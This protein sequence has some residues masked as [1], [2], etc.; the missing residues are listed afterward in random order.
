MKQRPSILLLAGLVGLAACG[1]KMETRKIAAA[2]PLT[3]R[4]AAAEGVEVTPAIVSTASF[5]A[6]EA[7]ELGPET[8]GVV[9]EVYV[10]VG[11]AVAA[12]QP[13]LRLESREAQWRLA[14]AQARVAEMEAVWRQAEARL[15]AD[16]RRNLNLSAEVLNAQ[17]A[18]DAAEEDARLA[19][20]E[21]ARANRLRT[22]KD[23]SQSSYDRAK[24]ALL[25]AEARRRGA[26]Q[27]LAAA[28]NVAQQSAQGIDIARAQ[29]ESARAQAAQAQKRASDTVLRAPFPGVVTA[30]TVSVGE[31]V[32]LQSKPLRVEKVDPLK[33]VFALP[34]ADA[35]RVQ[36]GL[37]VEAQVSALPGEVFRGKLRSPNGA[38][39]SA[40]RALTVEAEFANPSRRLKPGYFAEGKIL[41]GGAAA[42]LR[43]PAAA[44]D[45]DPRT[46]TYR[47]WSEVN[48]KAKLHLV[49][50]PRKAGLV[51]ELL[52]A[53]AAGLTAGARVI[54][55]PPPTLF[56]G[57]A[58]V[59]Q[60]N[61]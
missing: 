56:E 12:G 15:G 16:G 2:P 6:I 26:R 51:A 7:A 24:S 8:E 58:V 34:E 44:L 17:S 55:S 13:L 36:A 57:M 46:E 61:E 42:R 23:I 39:D 41:L 32:G 29:L 45:F 31:F 14:E 48:G 9:R 50:I 38:L 21:E 59:G 20:I 49:G 27:Q 5:A 35:A 28:Q 25:G 53:E 43:L 11:D 3:V 60:R 40:S 22:T 37:T 30:R 1:N 10:R 54:L 52:P 19:Q 47:V 18:V 4:T 33:L